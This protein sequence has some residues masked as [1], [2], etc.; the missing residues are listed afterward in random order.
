MAKTGKITVF[1]GED[2]SIMLT[3][4]DAD[5][6]AINITGYT[7]FF[8]VKANINDADADALISKNI[9]SHSNPS[10]GITYLTLTDA[11]TDVAVGQYPYDFKLKDGSGNFSQSDSGVFEIRQPVTTR[12][13]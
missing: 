4:T 2:K 9:T 3:F 12:E 10:G 7:I 1:R 13:S 8:T 6:V 5:G 11:D